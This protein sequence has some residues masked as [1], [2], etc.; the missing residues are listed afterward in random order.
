MTS[1]KC[2][3]SHLEG[4]LGA[5]DEHQSSRDQRDMEVAERLQGLAERVASME[6]EAQGYRDHLEVQRQKALIDPVTGL[7]NRAAWV[8]AWNTRSMRGINRATTCHWRC[9][10][11]S[12]PAHQRRLSHLAG[13]KVLKIIANVLSSA[14]ERQISSRGLAVRSLSC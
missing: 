4:L 1:S 11:G 2:W 7:P 3:K 12:L 6:Q 5:M 8:N 13:D 14:C 10:T 9:W